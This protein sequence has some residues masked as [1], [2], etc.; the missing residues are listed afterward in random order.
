[1]E[2][3]IFALI[4]LIV[5]ALLVWACDQVPLPH[6]INPIVKVLIIIIAALVIL[7]RAG[8]V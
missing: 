4:V 2:I 6:P 7:N 3:L 1:M 5:A 8:L